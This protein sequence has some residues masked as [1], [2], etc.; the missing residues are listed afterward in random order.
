MMYLLKATHAFLKDNICILC[1]MESVLMCGCSESET[2][3]KLSAEGSFLTVADLHADVG[4][5]SAKADAKQCC[6]SPPSR[7]QSH[8][9]GFA[10]HAAIAVQRWAM[11]LSCSI[12]SI[13]VRLMLQHNLTQGIRLGEVM[14][15][16]KLLAVAE[17]CLYAS[18][19]VVMSPQQ[20]CSSLEGSSPLGSEVVLW[21]AALSNSLKALTSLEFHFNW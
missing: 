3:P 15:T 21:L 9:G 14:E 8:P 10:L 13:P 16:I 17:L 19:G 1:A 7:E 12:S 20:G 2:L 6:M 5:S 18:K 11:Q 4:C